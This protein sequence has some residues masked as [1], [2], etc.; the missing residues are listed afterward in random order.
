MERTTRGAGRRALIQACLEEIAEHGTAEVSTRA[1][2]TR[3]GVTAPTLYH[4]FGDRRGLLSA[5]VSE[6]FE[7]Y[8]VA[9][10]SI[11]LSGDARKDLRAGW[12][13]HV[14]FAR[15]N[16]A[17]YQLMWPSDGRE[18]PAAAATSAAAL[19]AGFEHLKAQ[20]ALRT[21]IT[22]LAAAR[23]LSAAL[24]G[25]TDAITRDPDGPGHASM[26]ALIRNAVTSA[27]LE[28]ETADHHDMRDEKP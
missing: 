14:T 13:A 12:D 25:V 26:S 20:G 21:G 15:E 4:H 27:L 24:H 3:A 28:P 1:V 6:A 17:L 22:P 11:P 18:L 8:L 16:P 19:L 9:K 5:A 10:R 7:Q 2:C 23:A